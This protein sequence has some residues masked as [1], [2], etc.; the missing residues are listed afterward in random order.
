MWAGQSNIMVAMRARPIAERER[1]KDRDLVRVL[2]SKVVVVKDPDKESDDVLRVNRARDRRYAFDHAFGGECSQEEVYS[3]TTRFLIDG[4]VNGY[5]ATVFA[6]GATGA[7]KT[8]TM[9]GTPENPG[10]MILTLQDMFEKIEQESAARG[11]VFRV[12]LSYIEVYNEN[13]RDLLSPSPEYLDLREDPIKGPVVAGVTAVSATSTVEVMTMLRRG[14][15]NRTQEPT[16]ANQE[17]SRSHAVLQIYVEQGEKHGKSKKIGKLSLIDLAGSERASTT[18][19]KGIRLIEGANINRSLLALGN[20][21]NALATA[22]HGSFVPYRDSKLTRLLKDSLGGN[23]RTVMIANISPASSQFEETIN[24]LKYANRAKNIKTNVSRNVLNVNYHISEYEGLIEGL[25]GEITALKA[26]LAKAGGAMMADPTTPVASRRS[27]RESVAMTAM[28]EDLVANFKER[29]QLRRSLIELQAQNMQNSLEISR[30]EM[31]IAAW[32]ASTA[33]LRESGKKDEED[34]GGVYPPEAPEEVVVAREEVQELKRSNVKNGQLK[35]SIEARLKAN[36]KLAASIRERLTTDIS[37]DERRELL[38]LEYRIGL[39]ELDNMELEHSRMLHENV[40]KQRDM[41]IERLRTQIEARDRLIDAQRRALEEAGLSHLIDYE[42]IAALDSAYM[43]QEAHAAASAPPLPP[44]PPRVAPALPLSPLPELET[45]LVPRR[46][47][48]GR[49]SPAPERSV[50]RPRGDSAVAEELDAPASSDRLDGLLDGFGGKGA[51]TRSARRALARASR[52]AGK[53]EGS[54]P[55]PDGF[56]PLS[57]ARKHPR[58]AA[59]RATGGVP[60]SPRHSPVH[61]GERAPPAEGHFPGPDGPSGAWTDDGGDESAGDGGG[62]GRQQ[63]RAQFVSGKSSS[64]PQLVHRS[65]YSGPTPAPSTGPTEV[66]LD[67]AMVDGDEESLADDSLSEAGSASAAGEYEGRDARLEMG[68][69]GV[70]IGRSRTRRSNGTDRSDRTGGPPPRRRPQIPAKRRGRSGAKYGRARRRAPAGRS[71]IGR[72]ARG[73]RDMSD[74]SSG[75]MVTGSSAQARAQQRVR[76]K[77]RL[78]RERSSDSTAD[79][80][81]RSDGSVLARMNARM[82][83]EVKGE[84]PAQRHPRHR[85][86]RQQPAREAM[87]FPAPMSGGGDDDDLVVGGM[88]RRAAADRRGDMAGETEDSHTSGGGSAPSGASSEEETKH[89]PA[90]LEVAGAGFGYGGTPHSQSSPSTAERHAHGVPKSGH[91]PLQSASMS[92][93]SEPAE[94]KAHVYYSPT[95]AGSGAMP[96]RLPLLGGGAVQ[97]GPPEVT[98]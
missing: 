30:R 27:A 86:H 37:S 26:Q 91:S 96:S 93:G 52:S 95:P 55:T 80:I 4:V 36:E 17:S 61:F 63:A 90:S 47:G 56:S 66:V 46:G 72:R 74:D 67:M 1:R 39:L 28:R 14:N 12:T 83:A 57:G 92:P 43:A 79:D 97:R 76:E 45:H 25:R 73:D 78:R 81:E 62:A 13:L 42:E 3:H 49:G 20:C 21:I 87:V 23:C 53:V 48:G 5:N 41:T 7:G 68:I 8:Y 89:V 16:A 35:S 94:V 65:P 34:G 22:G 88:G 70:A 10:I 58:A 38:S 18:Q 40:V 19:N 85:H 29:M 9:L 59:V 50:P 24:T 11:L 51:R 84:R 54:H 31:S 71:N 77:R 64:L 44:N 33:A 15:K 82:A 75:V 32:E 6:Y 2:D 98:L 60:S 69:G